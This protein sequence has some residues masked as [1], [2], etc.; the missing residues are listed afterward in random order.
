MCCG[1]AILLSSC[2]RDDREDCPQGIH[3]QFY[4]VTP[5][6]TD[7]L[8]P[9]G[10]KLNLYV[11]DNDGILVATGADDRVDLRRDYTQ[12]L[13]VTDGLFTVMAWTGVED[14][15]FE[16]PAA[17][18][19]GITK[20]DVLLR[21]RR[22]AQRAAVLG[23]HR[24]Y[25][26]ESNVVHLPD[27][28]I[29]G[30]IFKTARINLQEQTNRIHVSVEGLTQADDYEVVIESRNG[31]MS[32]EGHI[33]PDELMSYPAHTQT[34]DNDGVLH[35]SFTTL[36]LA[37]GLSTTL[38]VRSRTH[39]NELYRGDLLG[40]LLLKNPGVDL[41]CDHDFNIAFTAADRCQCGEYTIMEIWVN[42]WLVHSYST[43]L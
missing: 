1:A 42:N 32:I 3:T 30:S 26:G 8:Y 25:Y 19:S 24:V 23:D 31:A 18:K 28:A 40:T 12:T 27:P 11:F 2:I 5:C 10:N 43:D 34:V 37:T 33:L 7:T 15:Y 29:Y 22:N 35:A 17:G 13:H 9:V 38:I 14:A 6:R 36:K 41:A 21:L 16:L 39:G 4:S 20:E